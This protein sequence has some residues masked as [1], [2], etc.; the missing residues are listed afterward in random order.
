MRK[1]DSAHQL[2]T[3]IERSE[4]LRDVFNRAKTL[5]LESYFVG[6]GCIT[7]TVWNHLTGRPLTYGISDIDIVYFDDANLSFEEEDI[8]LKRATLCFKDIPIPVDVKNQARV[9]LWYELKFG[10]R[11]NPYGSVEEAIT[12]WPTTAT[13]LGVRV[14][15]QGNWHVY[16][17]F[18]LEDLFNLTL[19]PNKTLITE[20]IYQQKV[21]KW[22]SKW[23]E[24]NVKAW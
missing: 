20:G 22:K 4:F 7:Q 17:P 8:I 13:S 5:E 3:I 18:G 23:P 24:L 6:A 2:I 16:A 12:T 19:R 15:Q 14:E 11:L 1:E 10:I 21:A 9:H